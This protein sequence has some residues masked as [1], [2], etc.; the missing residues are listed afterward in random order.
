MGGG[1]YFRLFPLFFMRWAINQ[2]G[3]DCKP[4][5]ANL[6]FHPWEFD[7]D[8]QRLPLGRLS[9]FRT[10]VGINRSRGRLASLLT[11]FTFCRA[12]DVAQEMQALLPSLP[13]FVVGS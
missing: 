12:V 6:Y 13:T 10:Y 3:R 2:T 11:Q 1:G 4:P 8:Q 7:P 5:V 9:R